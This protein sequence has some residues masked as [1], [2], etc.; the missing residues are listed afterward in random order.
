MNQHP[1]CSLNILAYLEMAPITHQTANP[2]IELQRSTTTTIQPPLTG[3]SGN[4][5]ACFDPLTADQ[6]SEY[7]QILQD[8]SV[9][10]FGRSIT[11]IEELCTLLRNIVLQGRGRDPIEAIEAATDLL[12]DV[13]GVTSDTASD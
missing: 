2:I 8:R 12:E 9:T 10:V 4:C 13:Q 7:E 11:T 5:A 1:S 6:K 3:T